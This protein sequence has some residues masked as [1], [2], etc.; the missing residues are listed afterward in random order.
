MSKEVTAV[1]EQAYSDLVSWYAATS[2][3]YKLG[4]KLTSKDESK[5]VYLLNAALQAAE[6]AVDDENSIANIDAKIGTAQALDVLMR[7]NQF[8]ATTTPLPSQAVQAANVVK[9][10]AKQLQALGPDTQTAANLARYIQRAQ[11]IIDRKGKKLAQTWA[12][13]LDCNAKEFW[14]PC[15]ASNT[16]LWVALGIA[17]AAWY[18][19]KKKIF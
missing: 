10:L 6:N 9:N 1:A 5:R 13:E 18:A 8:D 15:E 7:C 2:K 16:W 3:N 11:F 17:V 14:E 19:K 4:Q 12:N